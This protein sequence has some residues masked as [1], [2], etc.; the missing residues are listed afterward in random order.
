VLTF[1]IR[2]AGMHLVGS[3]SA[4]LT[5][6]ILG[7]VL[8]GAALGLYAMGLSLA[9][10]PHRISTAVIN[11][12]SLP[13][14]SRLQQEPE[15]LAHYFLK[16]SKYLALIALPTQI[17]LVLV[18]SDLVPLLLSPRWEAVTVPFQIMCAESALLIA[19]LAA[20]PMMTALGRAGFL[21]G[22]S[23][24]SVTVLAAATLLGS[25]FGL[26]GAVTARF[27]AVVPVRAI[28][29]L[30]C[31]REIGVPFRT[32]LRAMSSALVAT[33]AMVAVVLVVRQLLSGAGSV[34]RLA[35]SATIGA[36]VYSGA[37][38][39]LDRGLVSEVSTIGR[40][41]VSRSKA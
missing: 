2:I 24:L 13:V 15:E 5:A 23:V 26:V 14:F 18:A 30:P 39:F 36:L 8:G 12:I 7:R 40:E 32:Y 9:E 21:L 35:V 20:S 38:L 27:V 19:T 1:G 29:L 4:A 6:M 28:L 31:L 3:A 17:G 41:L 22:R 25:P 34:E 16:I 33:A 37:L 10:A 11:Q